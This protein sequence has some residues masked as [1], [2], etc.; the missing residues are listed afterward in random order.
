MEFEWTLEFI[1]L[2]PILDILE[3]QN[4][5][6]YDTDL[7]AIRAKYFASFLMREQRNGTM[8]PFILPESYYLGLFKAR[9]NR[10]LLDTCDFIGHIIAEHL[11]SLL[12]YKL[13]F[14]L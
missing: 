6:F 5:C 2:V 8:P 13:L 10:R 1:S 7:P 9:V 11:V 4:V 12:P 14:V 3:S